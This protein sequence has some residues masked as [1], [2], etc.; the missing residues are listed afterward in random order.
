MLMYSRKF[1]KTVLLKTTKQEEGG[2]GYFQN[3]ADLKNQ[4]SYCK[5]PI[6]RRRPLRICNFFCQFQCSFQSNYLNFNSL[7][8]ST[9]RSLIAGS[10]DQWH[11]LN[12]RNPSL[13]FL[14][15]L[16]DSLEGCVNFQ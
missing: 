11:F 5:F 16:S 7:Q 14:P 2:S 13:L 4:I 12:S 3:V 6:K 9:L 1:T 15:F 10:H 8:R